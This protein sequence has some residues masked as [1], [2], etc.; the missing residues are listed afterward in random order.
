[1][2]GHSPN[3]VIHKPLEH[4]CQVLFVKYIDVQTLAH[5]QL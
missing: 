2:R 3:L 5:Q 1:M 4:Y